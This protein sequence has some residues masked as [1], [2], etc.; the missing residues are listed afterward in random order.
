MT[1][2]SKQVSLAIKRYG[3]IM[4]VGCLVCF[5]VFLGPSLYN[6]P[7]HHY[8]ISSMI[9]DLDGDAFSL[10]SYMH[11]PPFYCLKSIPDR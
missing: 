7:N 10:L 2:L 9:N 4:I 6:L 8:L 11:R 3:K 5:F 1:T